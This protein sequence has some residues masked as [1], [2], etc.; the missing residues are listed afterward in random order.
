[1]ANVAVFH[2]VLGVRDGVN[3]AARR[4]TEAGH[5]VL[6]VDQYAGRS[7]DDYEEADA[8]AKG[9]GYPELMSRAVD[10]VK[11]L[12]DGF[13]CLGFSN[14]GGMSEHVASH[15]AISGAILVAGVLPLDMAGV[16]SWPSAVP[17]QVHYTAGDPFRRQDWI[18]ELRADVQEAGAS[19][20]MFEYEGEG[21][22]FTDPS[23]PHEFQSDDAELV[24]KR[25]LTFAPLDR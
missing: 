6:V 7:F 11:E 2:S 4:L 3:D 10:A 20:E 9:I 14:G 17:V 13:V 21:H 18:D 19:F 23:R 16:E 22:L 8:F 12:D 1:M 15:R 24:W 5:Q 25:V